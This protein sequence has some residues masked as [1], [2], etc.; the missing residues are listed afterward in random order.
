MEPTDFSRTQIKDIS[1]TDVTGLVFDIVDDLHKMCSQKIDDDNVQFT[2]KKFVELLNGPYRSWCWGEVRSVMNMG[3]TGSYGYKNEKI[4]FQ[5]LS[6]WMKRA[7]AGRSSNFAD[8]SIYEAHQIAGQTVGNFSDLSARW[9]EFRLWMQ[10]E[11][12]CF[13][14]NISEHKCNMF[15]AAKLS[16][17]L[18]D[19]KEMLSTEP[20][21][22]Y[23]EQMKRMTLEQFKK[24]HES[25]QVFG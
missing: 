11:H 3:V 4:N 14:D 10:D 9:K 7:Q 17:S 13:I 24:Q 2:V 21:P 12:L 16:G 20:D 6:T 23:F 18:K 8:K 5:T 22:E 15:H 25:E 1:R 19:F